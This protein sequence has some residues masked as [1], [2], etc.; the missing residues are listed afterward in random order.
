M[1]FMHERRFTD[2]APEIDLEAEIMAGKW[3]IRITDHY[4]F[5]QHFTSQ[6]AEEQSIIAT[7]PIRTSGTPSQEQ[8]LQGQMSPKKDVRNWKVNIQL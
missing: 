2:T 6:K 3:N 1:L 7:R 4:E 8:P 5:L